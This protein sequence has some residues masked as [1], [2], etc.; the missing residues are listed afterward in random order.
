MSQQRQLKCGF[1]RDRCHFLFEIVTYYILFPCFLVS[2]KFRKML[3]SSARFCQFNFRSKCTMFKVNPIYQWA[4]SIW[5]STNAQYRK[6]CIIGL[7]TRSC[8][9][10]DQ[11]SND[12]LSS[13]RFSNFI[14]QIKVTRWLTNSYKGVEDECSW[15]LLE[16][17]DRRTIGMSLKH[18]PSIGP[19]SMLSGAIIATDIGKLGRRDESQNGFPWVEPMN[20]RLD[21]VVLIAPDHCLATFQDLKSE[22]W[23]LLFWIVT[24]LSQTRYQRTHK[25]NGYCFSIVAR[26]NPFS[27]EY[28][29]G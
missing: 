11:V 1:L 2:T 17:N 5:W 16:A 25:Q 23:A 4:W 14:P 13:H 8:R 15:P 21:M 7:Y 26:S 9:K 18:L 27:Y 28:L 6:W 12:D 3:S 20:R 22:M 10:S 29:F 24:E 19:Q